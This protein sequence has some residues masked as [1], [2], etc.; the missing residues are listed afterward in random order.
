MRHPRQLRIFGALV[1]IT[2]LGLSLRLLWLGR[3]PLRGDEAFAIQYWA[4][5]W[6]DALALTRVEPHPFGTF[7]IFAVWRALFGTGELVMRLLSVLLSLPGIAAMYVIARQLFG[8]RSTGLLAALLYAVHP[9]LIWHAQDARNYA[10]WT[11]TSAIS[12]AAFL[13]ALRT[14]RRAHWR[15]YAI[16]TLF[17]LYTFFFAAFYLAAQA[18]Y[19]ALAARHRLGSW[20]RSAVIIGFGLIPWLWQIATIVLSSGYGGTAEPFDTAKLFSWFLPVYFAGETIPGELNQWLWP[21]FTVLA[22]VSLFAIWRARR[23]VFSLLAIYAVIPVILLWLASTRMNIFRPRYLMPETYVAILLV[24][25]LSGLLATRRTHRILRFTLLAGIL[26]LNSYALY[27]YYTNPAYAKAPDW[28]TL[29][30]FLTAHVAADDLVIEQALDPAFSY[31]YRGAGDETGLPLR[32]NPPAEETIAFLEDAVSRY[33]S[34]WLIPADNPAWDAERVPFTWLTSNLQTI[35]N[36]TIASFEVYQ[37]KPWEVPAAEFSSNIVTTFENI[38]TLH[39]IRLERLGSWL[40]VTV[41]WEPLQAP[42]ESLHG[43]AHLIGPPRPDSGSPLWAQNDHAVT[44]HHWERGQIRRDVYLIPLPATLPQS[45]YMLHVG[46]YDPDTVT[47]IAAGDDNHVAIPV[48]EELLL[49]TQRTG[50]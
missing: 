23:Q 25:G 36:L 30:A 27:G 44:D 12:L 31:Y 50:Q 34:I 42:A 45:N 22:V 2:L 20:M 6:P 39:D 14:N 37:F 11:A 17:N 3:S 7:A 35:A 9:F 10:L 15:R 32:A 29:G 41:Y 38:A 18:L 43:F 47:R 16:A 28:R 24:V 5:P 8:R 1:A 49:N 19:V 48:P 33:T 46:L 26:L 13:I 4:A 21:V 40:R